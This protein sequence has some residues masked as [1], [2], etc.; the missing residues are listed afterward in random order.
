MQSRAME[1]N[2]KGPGHLATG[3]AVGLMGLGLD[4]RNGKE[5]GG[6]TGGPQ[7]PFG[8][9]AYIRG[10]SKLLPLTFHRRVPGR[11]G[12]LAL[13]FSPDLPTHRSTSTM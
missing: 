9:Y 4:S 3:L 8:V 13:T 2:G 5:V 10:F 12:A 1:E 11:P 6:R 7:P